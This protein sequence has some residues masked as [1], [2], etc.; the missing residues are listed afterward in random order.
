MSADQYDNA[1]D[2]TAS[3]DGGDRDFPTDNWPELG[4]ETYAG[5]YGASQGQVIMNVIPGSAADKA[6]LVAGDVILTFNGQPVPSADT[7]DAAIDTAKGKFEV[8]V[9]DARTGR[10]S[11]LS[12]DLDP[13]AA[14]PAT[15][16]T[17][18]A[19]SK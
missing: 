6:G 17:A 7:L 5:E 9:W 13:A 1:D 3:N 18:F 12:G 8:S 11:T 15:K 2:N 10:K 19:P 14:A 16:T 4:L